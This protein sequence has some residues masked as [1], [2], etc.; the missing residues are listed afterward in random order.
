LHLNAKDSDKISIYNGL[1]LRF[2][3]EKNVNCNAV[4]K[5][6]YSNITDSKRLIRLHKKLIFSKAKSGFKIFSEKNPP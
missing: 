4:E 2:F 3:L 5:Y 6:I 1:C